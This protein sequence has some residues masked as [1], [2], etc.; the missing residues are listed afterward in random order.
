MNTE[1]VKA[2][3]E[4]EGNSEKK[5]TGSRKKSIAKRKTANEHSKEEGSSKRQRAE[6]ESDT[7]EEL[8][9]C[10]EFAKPEE[11][12]V[13][14]IPLTTKHHVV[15][16]KITTRGKLEYYEIFRAGG[17]SK[18]Y[19]V[20]SQL[21]NKFDRED[22]GALWKLVKAKHGNKRHKEEFERVLW[23]DLKV[24]FEPDT[25]SEIWR[26]L[27]GY[28]V[29]GEDCWDLKDFN[30]VYEVTAAQEVILNGNKVPKRKVR[31]TEQEYEP[32]TVEEKQDRRNERKARGTLLMALLNKDQ[33]KLHSYKD[34]KLLMEVIEK[35]YGGNKESKKVQRILLKQQYENFAGSSSETIDQTFDILQK[36]ISQLE[37][38]GSSISQNLQNVAFVS[39]NNTNSNSNSSTNEADNTTYRVSAA[40][41]QSNPTTGDNLCDA[42][43]EHI[44]PDDL[45]EMDLQWEMAML[46]IRARR[47]IKRTGRLLDVNGKRVGFD[48]SKVECYNLETP[49][50]NALVA[51]DGI[52]GYDWSYQAEEEHPTNF[53]LMAHTSS[54]N[55]S[56]SDSEVDSYSKS[57]V[58]AYASLKEQYDRYNA[59]S[60]T[61]ASLTVESFMNISEM[62]ENQEHNKSKSDKGYHAVPPFTGNFIPRKPN[63]TFMDEIVESENLDVT[64]IVT[65]SNVKAVETNHESA[66][67]KSN[68]DAV[69][70]KTVRKNSFRPPVIEDWNSND[71]SEVEIIPKDKVVSSST[72]KIKFVKFARET[73]EK[74]IRR[75]WNNLR[76]VNH[77]NFA[78]KMTHPH[79]NR[80]FV[81]Q[82]VLIIPGKISTAGASVNIVGARIN[83]AVRPVNTAGLKPTVNHPRSISNT[84]KKGYSQLTRP[85]NINKN[86]IFNKKV[87]TIRVKDTTS[88]D[89]A[90]GNPKQKEYKE[91]G[92]IDSG[93][94]RHMTGN[95]CYLTEY[96]DYDDGF[97]S[98][99]DGKGRISGKG[100]IK[101]GTLDFNNLLD[102]SQVLLRVSRKDNIYSVDL[103][104][105][106][107][108]KG[109]TCLFAKATIDESNLWHRRCDNGTEFKNSVMNQFCKMKGIKREFSIA[110][111]PQQNGVTERRNRTLIEAARTMLVDFKLPTTFWAEVVNTACYVLNKGSTRNFDGESDEGFFVGYSMVSK[112]MRVFNKRIRIVEETLNIRFLENATN[113]TG[114]RTDWLFDFDSLSKSMNYV[115]VIVENQTNGIAGKRDNIVADPKVSE[116]DA[117]EKT[118]EMDESGALDKDKEEDQA[119]RSE[120]ER[121]LQQEKQTIHTNST[122]SINTVST[123]ASTAGP[124]CTDDDLSSPVNVAEAS[125]AFEEHLFEQFSPFKNAF[126]LLPVSNVTPMNDTG[127]FC[128]AYDDE[129][130]SEEADLNNLETTMN[131]SPIPITRIDKDHPKD[132][133]I[134]DLNSA[135]QTRRMTKISDEHAMVWTLVDLPNGKRPIGTKWVFRNK[136]DERGIVVRN[137]ERL[138]TQGYTQEEGIDYD[139]VFAPVARIEAIRLFLAYAS[140]MRF[141]VYQMDMKSAFLYG[142][143]EEEVY[144]CQP[145]G[146][147]IHI[148][149]RKCIR[150]DTIDKTLF[151]K[152]DKGDILLVQVYVDD[153]IF[154]STKKSLC[155][156]FKGLMHKRFQMGYMGELTFFLGLQVQQKEDG[157]FISHDKY[158]AEILKKFDFAT[159]KTASTPMEPNKAL[160]K[161]KEAENV[162]VHLY[163]SMIRSLMYLTAS[164]PDIMFVVCACASFQVTPKTSHLHVVKRIFRYLKGQPKLGLWYPRDS[165]FDLEAF[166]DSDYAG[167]SLDRKFTT[168]GCQFLG[169]MAM[170]NFM[171]TMIYI[172]NE[173]TICIMKNL[174]F[175]SK[176]KHIEIRHHFIRDSYEKKLI[177]VIK[178][179][180]DYNVADLLTKAFDAKHIEY[181]DTKIPQS[182]GPP[183]KVNDEAVHKG[184]GNIMERA[185]TT[186]SSLEAEQDNANINRTQSMATLN[187]PNGEVEITATIDGQLK[188]ITEASLRRHLKLEDANGISS[189]PNTK[190]FKQLALMGTFNFSKMIF[191]AMGEGSTVLVESYHTP[192]TTPST[193]QPP[194]SSPSG[195]PTPPHDSPLLGCHTPGSNEGSI[196]L[197]ELTVL[198]TQLLTKVANLEQDLKQTK[199]VYGNAYTKLIMRVKKL[200]HKVKSRQPRRK[201]RV[202]AEI[203]G[204]TSDDT[205]I[206]L[207]QEEPT[208]LVE[209]LG[210]GEKGEKEIS[211]ANISISTA[212]ATPKKKAKK[213]L[214][215]ERLG[216]K[217]A[218]R[219]QEQIN[220]KERQRISRDAEIAKQLQEEFDRARQEQEVVAE[221]DQA[222]DIDCSD[223][224]MLRYHAL[225]NRSFSVAE[226][227]EIEKEV[228]KIPGFDFLQKSIKKNDKIKAS[229]FVQKQP[230]EEEKEKKNDDSQQ[231]AGSSK[232]RSREDSDEDNA[233]KQKLEDGAENKELRDSMDVVLRDDIAIDVESLATKYP[234]LDWKTHVLTENM[235]YYQIIRADGCSKN[236]KIFS[237]MLDDFDRQDILFEPNE[238]DEIWKN[239]QDYNLISW[240]L[241]DSCGTHILLMHTG[242]DIHMMIEKIY[243]LTHEMLSRMLSRRLEV[244]PES[245][246]AFELL[247]FK[248]SQL[249]K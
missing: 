151:I 153:I 225:Q 195:V 91:K 176:T 28:K 206:L 137:K 50:K 38:Q 61:A 93:C 237:E 14:A 90:V 136:K 173:S 99:G 75:V 94:S 135:I 230:P 241:F 247:R 78:N 71:E 234:I 23:D 30:M 129:D 83:T 122:N 79:P 97:V 220:E 66:S 215:Q 192:F 186:A 6:D 48:M 41:T 201:A 18:V 167:A 185:A 43:L 60:S 240:R 159:V 142:T 182:S 102:E 178:I 76:R 242:I 243:P 20:F 233:K 3:E 158:V 125:N 244:N 205:A 229:S 179:H 196:T 5:T 202:D 109:L 198:Y 19:H 10:F 226:D 106:V 130:V 207:D 42:D 180:I 59:A 214:K 147:K 227:S 246:M 148:F 191:E 53:A 213:Q 145:P 1:M 184:L 116:E 124:S 204:R 58:K 154:G 57:C 157:T 131:V 95:K 199:K 172:D 144:V 174:V 121:L 33:L 183:E 163:R 82:A 249:Q 72:E 111:T 223:P 96:E 84:Y 4:K 25:T 110:R 160:V 218:I 40:H 165:P 194:L 86:S 169:N 104:S 80:R 177:Q 123:P 34:A 224:A 140:F 63:L 67:V 239:Q 164:R 119:T 152:K 149:L 68:G 134:G 32:T 181:L 45:E 12:E 88:R 189:L 98:F 139:E 21:Q 9:K 127:I 138:V 161:D 222:H 11:V 51:Q 54:G 31:E 47:F 217:E 92:V 77:K 221:A 120:F 2:R 24:M 103:K 216:H 44:D 248:R 29:T 107:P 8:K 238:A 87:N 22:L 37:I 7:E 150:R 64:T 162:D 168:G 193:S 69:E 170:F 52:G 156:E 132:Q 105:G 26:S 117:E 141:I 187:E 73:V 55:S 155:D 210:S 15:D 115:P 133:I 17:V 209:D 81:P 166:S 56:S 208:E 232:K 39:S 211:T 46:T 27:Q 190:I 146:L 236:Y 128:N 245:E 212:S 16:Y 85:F 143:S 235:M 197:N 113:V 112:A 89:R 126:T 114:N 108:I 35:K 118:T 200:E 171:N 74:V 65:P 231:Q 203:Q 49:N 13:N 188:T 219:L 62:L 100:K 36:L 228:M 101:T 70:P 175:H